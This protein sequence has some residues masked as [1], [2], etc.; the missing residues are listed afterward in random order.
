MCIVA[1]QWSHSGN[2]FGLGTQVAT[3]RKKCLGAHGSPSGDPIILTRLDS[4][5]HECMQVH[6]PALW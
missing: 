2:F 1:E 3:G 4:M 6:L 5:L